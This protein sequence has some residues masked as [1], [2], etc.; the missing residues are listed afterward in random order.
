MEV[1]D[2]EDEVAGLQTRV[3]KL[4]Q[5]MILETEISQHR[6]NIKSRETI[7]HTTSR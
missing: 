6:S 4:E 1:N 2:L 5:Q 7:E 3:R